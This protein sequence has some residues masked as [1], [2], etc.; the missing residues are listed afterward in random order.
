MLL[1]VAR[2]SYSD[3]KLGLNDTRNVSVVTPITDG[4]VAVDW[5]RAEIAD[6]TVD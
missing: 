4:A 3:A 5:D 2:V 6:F 1:G